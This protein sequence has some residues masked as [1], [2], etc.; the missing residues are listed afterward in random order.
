[1]KKK[2]KEWKPLPLMTDFHEDRARNAVFSEPEKYLAEYFCDVIRK[3]GSI[4]Y[5]EDQ[6]QQEA[7]KRA[8]ELSDDDR[9][10]ILKDIAK[11]KAEEAV[12]KKILDNFNRIQADVKNII[13]RETGSVSQEVTP[14][15]A[16][17]SQPANTNAV[18][19][20]FE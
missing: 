3:D 16:P 9:K 19:D 12:D 5:E 17:Q 13:A 15:Q 14:V 6:L 7:I 10:G 11:K 1:M 4:V 2:R 8:G 18:I 20:P